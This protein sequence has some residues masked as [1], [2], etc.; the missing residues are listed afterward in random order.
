MIK[1]FTYTLITLLIGFSLFWVKAISAGGESA[2]EKAARI[3]QYDKGPKTIDVSKYPKSIQEKYKLFSHKC[4]KCHTLA[5]PINSD[6]ALPQ[7]WERYV[8]RMKNK[9]GS[10]IS[11]DE[12][13]TIYEFLV[14]DSSIRKKAMIDKKLEKM[15]P[16]EKKAVEDKI[17]EIKDKEK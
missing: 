10:G 16:E 5:R 11:G 17:K 2:S 3:A 6:Y 9:P 8:K 14:Y 12:A 13:K 7:E 1:V 15:T 4:T